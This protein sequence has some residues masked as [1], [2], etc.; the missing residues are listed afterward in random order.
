MI[1]RSLLSLLSIHVLARRAAA[2]DA[3]ICMNTNAHKQ[4]TFAIKAMKVAHVEHFRG[5][6]RLVPRHAVTAT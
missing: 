5:N 3:S 2:L 4:S 6:A 1:V